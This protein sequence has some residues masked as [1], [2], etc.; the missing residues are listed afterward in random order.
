[1]IN[2]NS[3][4]LAINFIDEYFIDYVTKISGL[5]QSFYNSNAW[6]MKIIDETSRNLSCY[7]TMTLINAKA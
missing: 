1:M 6:E 5:D 7:L 4:N 3:S 2:S